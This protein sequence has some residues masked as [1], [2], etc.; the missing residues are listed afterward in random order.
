MVRKPGGSTA[1]WFEAEVLPAEWF[2]DQVATVCL[3]PYRDGL[4]TL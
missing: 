2:E 3:P 4:L 1:E